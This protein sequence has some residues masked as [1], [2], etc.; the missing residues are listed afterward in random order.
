[1]LQNQTYSELSRQLAEMSQADHRLASVIFTDLFSSLWNQ[2]PSANGEKRKRVAEFFL[3][4]GQLATNGR[5]MSLTPLSCFYKAANKCTTPAISVDSV[6]LENLA[7]DHRL[8][9]EGKHFNV[10]FCGLNQ[11]SFSRR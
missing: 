9:F 5:Q 6:L 2:I 7:V 3:Q 8:W 11:D 4:S 1:M 10:V